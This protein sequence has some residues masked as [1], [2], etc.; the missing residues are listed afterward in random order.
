MGWFQQVCWDQQSS[1][2]PA[3][4]PFA[5]RLCPSPPAGAPEGHKAEGS[6]LFLFYF[7]SFVY[8]VV[9]LLRGAL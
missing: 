1:A 8:F 6:N 4:V 5:P 7:V 2:C 3:V 9:T